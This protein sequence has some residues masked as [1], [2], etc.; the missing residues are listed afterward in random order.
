MDLNTNQGTITFPDFEPL[1]NISFVNKDVQILRDGVLCWRGLGMKYEDFLNAQ[2]MRDWNLTVQSNKIYLSREIFRKNG[3]TSYVYG[4]AAYRINL[5]SLSNP[6]GAPFPTSVSSLT[7]WEE[8]GGLGV[9]NDILACQYSA[10]LAAG[11][12]PTTSQS[13]PHAILLVARQSALTTLQGLV[14]ST[15]YEVRFNPNNTVDFQPQV[16]SS[17][18][19]MTFIEGMNL[20]DFRF[21]YGIDQ[22]V[23]DPVVTG[24]GSATGNYGSFT[25]NQI[26]Q[27]PTNNA[28]SIATYGRWSQVYSFPNVTDKN[29]LLAYANALQSDLQK[30]VYTL[31]LL[32]TLP[33]AGVPFRV[34][35]V[36]AVTSPSLSLNAAQY[37]IIQIQRQYDANSGEQITLTV[38]PNARMVSLTH[39]RLKSLQYILNNQTQINQAFANT[40]NSNA[41][42]T[43][44]ALTMGYAGPTNLTNC[45]F[46]GASQVMILSYVNSFSGVFNGATIQCI[47]WWSSSPGTVSLQIYDASTSPYYVWYNNTVSNGTT[48]S[49]SVPPTQDIIDHIIVIYLSWT[50]SGQQVNMTPYINFNS[51]TVPT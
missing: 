44:I 2:N 13:N 11:Q 34:G 3:N 31:T 37:R 25:D 28:S 23:N 40:V 33:V 32:V 15:L 14:N 1:Q 19:V 43:S 4:G 50:S 20:L 46:Y 8:T 16:G 42:S 41:S 6:I 10:V 30:P 47:P 49:Y 51:P 24:A 39:A 22:F 29:T 36:I 5:A 7:S 21:Q 26:F 18:P 48:Y 17:T 35:D 9:F 45:Y 27:E 12:V 38:Q